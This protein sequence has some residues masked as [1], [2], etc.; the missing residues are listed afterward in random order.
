MSKNRVHLL[1]NDYNVQSN[2]RKHIFWGILDWLALKQPL[3]IPVLSICAVSADK[4]T[5]II[6]HDVHVSL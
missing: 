2:L 5:E 4:R 6:P 1:N 3:K